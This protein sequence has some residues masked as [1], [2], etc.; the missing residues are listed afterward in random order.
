MTTITLTTQ[1]MNSIIKLPENK[2][3]VQTTPIQASLVSVEPGTQT[4][5][6]ILNL[7]T[8]APRKYTT[9]NVRQFK[10][11]T[12]VTA[13]ISNITNQQKYKEGIR[14]TK[15]I[16]D[17]LTELKV[18]SSL[19]KFYSYE[20]LVKDAV[21]DVN[22]ELKFSSSE[23]G[24][25]K[26]Q[27][28]INTIEDSRMGVY[29]DNETCSTCFRNTANCI[30]HPGIIK[31]AAPFFLAEAIPYVI[32]ILKCI[33]HNCGGLLLSREE[34]KNK[35]ILKK[36]FKNRLDAFVDTVKLGNNKCRNNKTRCIDN[37]TISAEKTKSTNSGKIIAEYKKD[38]KMR[39]YTAEEV[40]KIFEKFTAEE[41]DS[42]G[43]E[44]GATPV[45]LILR[46]LYVIPI[47]SRPPAIRDGIYT[48]HDLSMM[49]DD[50]VKIN[51]ALKAE[52]EKNTTY[53]E[54]KKKIED[55][56]LLYENFNRNSLEEQKDIINLLEEELKIQERTPAE[57]K[58]RDL[59]QGY[60]N[61]D[62]KIKQ[63]ESQKNK[64]ITE[65]Q[66]ISNINS[67]NK[68]QEDLYIEEYT[69]IQHLMNNSDGTW[70]KNGNKQYKGIKEAINGKE[71]L[72]RGL[73]MGR[74]VNFAART[75]LSP[76]P[77]LNFG[78]I[79]VPKIW[80]PIL[81]I[82]M[83]V[84]KANLEFAQELYNQKKVGFMRKKD[85]V[86]AGIRIAITANNINK[87]K[88]EVGDIIE[89]H[90][91]NGD[92]IIFNRQPTIQKESMMGY[93]VVLGEE[94]TIGVHPSVAKAHNADND[95]DEG[96]VHQMQTTAAMVELHR[97]FNSKE[98]IMNAQSNRAMMNVHMDPVQAAYMMTKDKNKIIDEDDY[99]NCIQMLTVKDQLSS[100]AQRCNKYGI[101]ERSGHGLFS[102]LL[103]EDFFYSKG[104]VRIIEGV[105]VAG[106]ITNANL[107]LSSNSLIEAAYKQYGKER[108]AAFITDA[109]LLLN[110]YALAVPFSIRYSD[111]IIEE[112]EKH[113]QQVAE[114]V[115]AAELA[116]SQ[117]E[118]TRELR[119]RAE[120]LKGKKDNALETEREE[121]EII[122]IL[123]STRNVGAKTVKDYFGPDNGLNISITSKVKG[124]QFNIAQIIDLVGQQFIDSKRLP[125]LMTNKTRCSPYFAPNDTSI[126]SQGFCTGNYFEGLKPYEQFFT[127]SGSRE[128]TVESMIK[129]PTSGDI[130]HRMVKNF[131]DIILQ[132]NGTV[133][134]SRD[135]IIQ[136]AYED[137]FSS[138]EMIGVE[139][140]SGELLSFTNFKVLADKLNV[141]YG[142]ASSNITPN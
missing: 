115:K 28:T 39:S 47:I 14:K 99:N 130:N 69:K 19:L 84:F 120:D 117:I 64:L 63:L 101:L 96:N 110:Q 81:T 61:A 62:L 140:R 82:P 98:C 51:N 102:T 80:A 29:S 37:P 124:D 86:D 107:G 135:R 141:K 45:N 123:N 34:L 10:P 121:K 105:M 42:L 3:I 118:R 72:I 18:E 78:Q 40:L 16:E 32:K 5:A 50:I 57:A 65:H 131:E 91:E 94:N 73:I 77:S 66:N 38:N 108:A 126:Q 127:Q 113:K 122:N 31:L 12:N 83:K 22:R 49:Y 128:N 52:I 43:F 41:I 88:V 114:K 30:G 97:L 58:T 67:K 134:N 129:V 53:N 142:Y 137:G 27:D 54:R 59:L 36:R 111:C 109:N 23:T 20:E 13:N 116:V 26:L 90:M 25:S 74:R 132:N 119:R 15:Q 48:P 17:T 139:T 55:E 44:N 76:D 70:T 6:P 104:N 46:G 93:E 24:N 71:E 100:I 68:T 75:V 89:R 85:G 2:Q 7:V 4:S 112:D 103:P 138:N 11:N 33:C 60:R 79:R 136:F 21:V 106:I 95:G 9:A 133:T 125:K 87:Y 1:K 8:N 35:G 92:N 56:I